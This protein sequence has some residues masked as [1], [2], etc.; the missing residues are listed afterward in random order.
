[1]LVEQLELKEAVWD[2]LCQKVNCHVIPLEYPRRAEHF[3]EIN[4]SLL[5]HGEESEPAEAFLETFEWVI[6]E[7]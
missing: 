3:L 1:M 5:L 7:S 4:D 6:D 2:N